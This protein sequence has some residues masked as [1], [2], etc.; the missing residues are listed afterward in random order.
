M[1]KTSNELRINANLNDHLMVSNDV[2]SD[3]CDYAL[4]LDCVGVS[5]HAFRQY[6]VATADT[7]EYKI[8][9]IEQTT[10]N[11]VNVKFNEI[12]TAEMAKRSMRLAS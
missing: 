10:S 8:R 6:A 3:Y 11:M 5:Q 1:N 4:R 7:I 12:K 2:I 9:R